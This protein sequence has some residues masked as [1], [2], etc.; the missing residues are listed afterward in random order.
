MGNADKRNKRCFVLKRTRRF[1]KKDHERQKNTASASALTDSVVYE[2]DSVPIEQTDNSVGE[3]E[4]ID[5]N[6]IINTSVVSE[7]VDFMNK[8]CKG[9]GNMAQRSANIDARNKLGL[10]QEIKCQ[11]CMWGYSDI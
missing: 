9:C 10:C 1:G 7:I 5:F 8:P 6:F 11:M 2:D 4:T 3:D